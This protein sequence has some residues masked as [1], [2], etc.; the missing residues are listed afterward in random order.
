[1]FT[2]SGGVFV[3]GKAG[4]GVGF[5]FVGIVG[6]GHV[7]NPLAVFVG[8]AHG[9]PVYIGEAGLLKQGFSELHAGRHGVV[10]IYHGK[11]D[12]GA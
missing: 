4:V 3:A 5:E 7:F 12:I 2:P 9:R 6:I 10:A 8:I 11:V 1:M